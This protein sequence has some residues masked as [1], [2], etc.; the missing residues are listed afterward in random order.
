VLSQTI[1]IGATVMSQSYGYD[2]LN[3]LESASENSG[4]SWSQTYGYDRYGNR[5]VSASTGYTLSSLTPTSAG[6]FNATNN[7]L[8]ASGYDFA[9]NQTA[10][11][12]GR[13]F[14]YD[15]E[16][17]QI[18]FNGTAGQY[19][20]DGDGRR[21][22]KIDSSGTTVFVYD[23]TGRMIAEY[24]SDPVPPASGGGG[25]SYLT[26]DHLGSTRVVTKADGSVK[27]RYDYLP[28]G[29][30]LGATIGSRTTAMGYSAADS[31]KQKFTQKERDD[32][33]GLDYFLARYYSS[34]QGRFTSTDPIALT[35]ER[36]TD[37][38]G[39]N[40]YGYTRNN[41]L[42][43]ID[44]TGEIITFANDDAPQRFE[45][46]EKFLNEDKKKYA[47][48]LQTIKQLKGSDVEYQLRVGGNFQER[49]EGNVTTDGNRIF[50]S[51]S[52]V[53]GPQ[54][55][56][57]SL[58]SRFAHEL[59]HARQFDSGEFAFYK[60]KKGEW[61]TAFASYDI[62]DEV[63]A[64]NAQLNT[65]TASDYWK[66]SGGTKKPSTLSQLSQAKTDD[67]RA[68][69]LVRNG[70]RNRNSHQNS[71]VRFSPKEGYNPGQLIRPADRPGF[72]GRVH[73]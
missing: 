33:S 67:E 61:H 45:A 57:F 11:A 19:F 14:T 43:F 30:E 7:K 13:S 46:Y 51:V 41:P 26:T 15:A 59:E 21:V 60:D 16:N 5:W 49:A 42:A 2:S 1:T 29:E 54:G 47:S 69:V 31:T 3:R 50:V 20:Y 44:P 23:V 22:K 28:F 36:L 10:D 37:P 34:A 12:Q 71:N 56:T 48:E 35:V 73:Q 68:G 62:G 27:A 64:W 32:E 63:K 9:G 25:T 65:A 17:R 70:Y 72:F 52:N 38:Q 58:N 53:G 8:I 55:E 40:L 39:I 66:D 24:H 4:G 6:A 18:T